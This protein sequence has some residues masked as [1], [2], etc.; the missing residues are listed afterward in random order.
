MKKCIILFSGGLDSLLVVKIMK[1]LGFKITAVFLKLPFL[2]YDFEF[3]KSFCDKNKVKFEVIDCS[4][5]NNFKEYLNIIKNP[6][7]GRGVSFNPCIDCKIF[8]FKKIKKI[9]K[10]KKINLIVSG[11]VLEERPFSQNFKAFSLIDKATS[12][13]GNIL[14][15][16]SG[17]LLNKTN[18]E[19]KGIIN[20]ENLYSIIGRRRIF[21]ISLAKEFGIDFYPQPSGGCLLCERIFKKRF[22]ILIKNNLINSKN[23]NLIKI[24]RHFFRKNCWFVVGR[25]EKENEIIEK[26]KNS[27][28]SAKSK[29]AVYYL[30]KE[31]IDFAKSLQKSYKKGGIRKYSNYKI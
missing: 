7:Y 29:P 10:N 20:R 28:K 19:I 31:H 5:G 17:K 21:Q 1:K 14:R 30:L 2:K 24:G 9:A 13:E 4:K 27:I 18:F 22:D 15:P 26:F 12:L 6:V 8:M 11:D 16:L 25:N 3:M 23:L